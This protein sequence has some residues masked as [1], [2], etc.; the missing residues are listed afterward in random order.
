MEHDESISL[1]SSRTR[2]YD[3]KSERGEKKSKVD[4]RERKMKGSGCRNE[5]SKP[6]EFQPSQSIGR[7]RLVP[8]ALNVLLHPLHENLNLESTGGKTTPHST[9]LL[10]ALTSLKPNQSQVLV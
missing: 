6:I 7:W 10:R 4:Q 9:D 5:F 2:E 1:I 8:D 3:P